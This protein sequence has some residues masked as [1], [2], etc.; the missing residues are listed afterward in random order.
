MRDAIPGHG[1][2]ACG[3]STA[4][5]S[6][7][8]AVEGITL[9]RI[10]PRRR[11]VPEA[12]GT[13]GALIAVTTACALA[14]G[15]TAA[16]AA[17]APGEPRSAGT[18]VAGGSGH[19]SGAQAAPTPAERAEQAE[20]RA[21]RTARATGR[22]V[23]VDALTTP[24]STTAA[25]PGGTL[26]LTQSAAPVRAWQDGS[27]RDLDATL[28]V[29]AD[30]SLSP[31]VSTTG[32]TLSG[33]GTGPLAT[34]SATGHVLAL[35]WPT[36]LP[37][38]AV[39]GATATYP[40]V[41]PGVDLVV[42]ADAQ[43]GFS[44]TLVVKN[45]RAAADPA[46]ARLTME[47]TS[48]DLT[49]TADAAGGLRAAATGRGEP[50]FTAAPPTM[51][52]SATT[53]ATA[54]PAGPG[55]A[56]A[57]TATAPGPGAHAAPIEATAAPLTGAAAR[58]AGP[59]TGRHPR[60]G[61]ISLRPDKGLLTDPATVYPVYIDPTWVTQNAGSSRQAWAQTD[62][63][64]KSAAHW[65]PSNLQNGYCG[66]DTCVPT[67]T[68]ESYVRMSVPSQLQ[69]AQI[70]SSELD[71][72]VYHG[73]YSSC[74]SAPD[75]GLELWWT[76]GISS[77]TTWNNAPAWKQ[78]INTQYPAACDG[79]NVGFPITS[80]MQGHA[81]GVSSLTFGIAAA[82]ESDR[83]AWK[84]IHASTLT[85]STTYDRAPTLPSHPAVSPGGPCQTGTPSATVVGNDDVTF[86]VVSADP[87]GGQLGTEFVIKN[88]GGATVYDSGDARTAATALT[89]SSGAVVR[90]TLRRSQIQGWHPDGATKAYAYSWY[91]RSS[92]G[93]L[94]SP[95]TGVGSAGSPCNFV[96]D[97]TQP[98]AP[99]IAVSTDAAGDA[100][101]LGQS[102][103]FTLA[104]CAG[105]LA[106][107]PT[108]CTG[109]APNRY[110][111]QVNSSPP[112]S[113]TATGG[114]Q[115]VHIPLTHTGPNTLT[116]FAVS[117]GG[118]PGYSAS[119]DFTVTGPATPY[120][121]GDI[122]GDSH[123]DLLTVG[124]GSNPGLWLSTGDG[125][126]H[127]DVP[128]DIGAAGTAVD[129]AGTPADWLG[130]QV[131]HG[132]FTG[133]HV[134][135]VLAY[136]PAGVHAGVSSVLDGNGD[137]LPLNPYSGS[138]R[139]L[140][141]GQFADYTL[142][143]DG[144]DP[145]VLVAAGNASL[146]GT[147]I[148]DLIGI[149]GDAAG[150]YQLDLFTTCGGCT[151]NAY[152]YAQTLAGP[153]DSPDGAADWENF[154][155]AAAQPGGDTVLFALKK[156]TG[157]IWEAT[158]PSRDP[159]TPVG[160]ASAA[161][162]TWT[163]LTVPWTAAPALVSADVTGSGAVELWARSGSTA[164]AYT[165]SGSSLG[166]SSTVAM[167]DPDHEWPLTSSSGPTGSC[168]AAVCTPDTRG[169]TD[170]PA[171]GGVTF[172]D[173][174]TRGTVADLDGTGYLTAPAK[175]IESAADLTLTLSFRADPGT[176]GILVS[177]G[178]DTPDKADPDAMPVMYIGT[179]GRLYAQFWNGAVTPMISPQPVD[180]GQWHT[181][182]LNAYDAGSGAYHQG[183]FLDNL[184]RIGMAGN[185][186]ISLVDPLD[187][188]G[189]GVFSHSTST[190]SWLNA[191][192]D[193][194]KDRASYFKGRISG[195]A[196]YSRYV[197]TA[198]LDSWW[199]PVP[200]VGP[201][202]SGLSSALCLDDAGSK[203]A[204][205]NKVQIY[206]CNNTA[207]QN[208]SVNPHGTDNTVTVTIAGVTKCLDVASAGT[209]NGTLVQLYTCNGT[210]AQNWHL[211]SSGQLWNPNS[212]KCLDDPG[213][214]TTNGTQLEI[215]TCNLGKNQYWWAA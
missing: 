61:T 102:A 89:S 93:K 23:R 138:Q 32:L 1:H 184:P 5:R 152:G 94:Y 77:S 107:P 4:D 166:S 142:N 151:A 130:A 171:T 106:D 58:R 196:F 127:L 101:A 178:H 90:L 145:V 75:P 212:G 195:F 31:N 54:R 118:N 204:D 164:T 39:S 154:T 55:P 46:L 163:R 29:N 26:T 60:S 180:D 92:D 159:L 81:Q 165:L 48:N 131:L 182:T 56:A 14:L 79:Q 172:P 42:T 181:A 199:K 86:A 192:G 72:T 87:D 113:V 124:T 74:S 197:S 110:T 126:G 11:P 15:V 66:W 168:T 201:I 143:G 7:R 169:G 13:A 193:T 177:T 134:Q 149:A 125:A 132:D 27:W 150:G 158:N 52:D 63:I 96:Y 146:T 44:D 112:L 120:T 210:A 203:T 95:A 191:P 17:G 41:L 194:A 116:V 70:Y 50:V 43:G 8:P 187:F 33:G 109:T 144:D 18:A 45:R 202:V 49:V 62:T 206:T 35:S 161:G 208:W 73:P 76:G 213:Y 128:V 83:N 173:D 6:S 137:K 147:G 160:T 108:A 51:W 183:L 36:A 200:L 78:K 68:A 122:D 37:A 174:P 85:M 198:Q 167:V 153:A 215:Y 140:P 25:D 133:N 71:L 190:K 9:S 103:A 179:D 148:D 22:S 65:K 189:A 53:A 214:S 207:A 139:T 40:A 115:T 209:A 28:H 136:Y 2:T 156:T 119:A 123:P 185:S 16:S 12:R 82:S 21:L 170:I 97:P 114:P 38:P 59:G 47:A 64:D 80:F 98:P 176:N 3:R 211:D 69:G 34:M 157:E 188:I 99:G 67:F 186:T 84:Q 117:S 141:A 19:R 30:H 129:T 162:G 88:H 104:P 205:K 135:D 10:P 91:T 121:D 57:S 105:A 175:M 20:D 24:T 155:L 100:G 111:Y